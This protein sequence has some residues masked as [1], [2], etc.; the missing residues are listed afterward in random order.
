MKVWEQVWVQSICSIFLYIH[1]TGEEV[2]GEE[3]K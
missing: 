1:Y 3:V 2:T